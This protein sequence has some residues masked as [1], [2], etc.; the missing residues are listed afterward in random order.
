MK[1]ITPDTIQKK[2]NE[3]HTHTQTHPYIDKI[4]VDNKMKLKMEKNIVVQSRDM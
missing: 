1:A 4:R 2:E 3:T